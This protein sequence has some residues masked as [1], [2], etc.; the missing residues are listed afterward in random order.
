MIPRWLVDASTVTGRSPCPLGNWNGR[1]MSWRRASVLAATR[2]PMPLA[3]PAVPQLL[4]FPLR[5]GWQPHSH[6]T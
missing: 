5:T 6:R 3:G 4:D 1:R 2:Q